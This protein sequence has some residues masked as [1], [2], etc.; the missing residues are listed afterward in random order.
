MMKKQ[1][2]DWN[3][4]AIDHEI[5]YLK[6]DLATTSPESYTVE[7]MRAISEGMDASTAE[8]EAALKADFDNMPPFAQGK[9][10]DLLKQ[11]DPSNYDWWCTLLVG[12]MPDGPDQISIGESL[13]EG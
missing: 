2:T 1:M 10:L 12:E 8:V 5:A 13:K 9:M 4:L 6:G 11:A 3:Q 7:E